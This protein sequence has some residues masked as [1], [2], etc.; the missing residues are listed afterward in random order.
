LSND[1]TAIVDIETSLTPTPPR[2]NYCSMRR[3]HTGVCSSGRITLIFD[4]CRIGGVL[5][6]LNLSS[7]KRLL[8]HVLQFHALHIGLSIS[9]P[10]FSRPAFSAPRH[11]SLLA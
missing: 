9:R 5:N 11:A 3:S 6:L 8:F 7:L 4:I 2:P 1:E 10:S